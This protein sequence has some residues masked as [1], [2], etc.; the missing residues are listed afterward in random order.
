IFNLVAF[1]D[2]N[3][4]LEDYDDENLYH[5]T[6]TPATKDITMLSTAGVLD[7]VVTVSYN[8]Y[9]FVLLDK[10]YAR[11][12]YI[13]VTSSDFGDPKTGTPALKSNPAVNGASVIPTKL[14]ST[15]DVVVVPNPYRADKNYEE[16]GWENVDASDEWKEQDRKIV[17]LNVPFRSVIK[18]YTL[19]GDLVKTIG[20]NGNARVD[21]RYQYG[22]Y[23]AA[24][25]LINENDQAVV[26]GIYLFS[27]QDVDNDSYDYIGKFV[28]IK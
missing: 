26:S 5:F 23:G 19:A 6:S 20:H 22:E 14:T 12:S 16:M 13:A 1:G 25:D 8:E 18:I 7:S 9:R 10:L 24:W 3:S 15:E 4:L 27:V 17:F 21:A 28:I 2:N 11:E